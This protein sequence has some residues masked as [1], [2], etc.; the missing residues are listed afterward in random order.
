MS[1]PSS[2]AIGSDGTLWVG[3]FGNHRVLRFDDAAEKF[4]GPNAD[5]VLGQPD[6]VS[7]AV[8]TGAGDFDQP[9]ALAISPSGTLFVADSANHRVLRFDAAAL[10]LDGADADSVLGQTNLNGSVAPGLSR[11]ALGQPSALTLDAI[12][13]LFVSDPDNSRV[14][15]F[16]A[17][18]TTFKGAPASLVLG[19]PDFDTAAFTIT[20]T[21]VPFA[22]GLAF[23]PAGRLFIAQPGANRI[24]RFSPAIPPAPPVADTT[25]PTIRVK[26]RRSVDS[27]RNRVVFRG[28]ASDAD[29]VAGIEFRVSGQAGFQQAKGTTRWKAVVRPDKKKRKTVVRVRAI[30]ASGNKSRF[31][32]LKIFRR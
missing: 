29:A 5:G 14:L 30:D 7:R 2:V 10:A 3:E 8:G 26:G 12:G 31:L 17:A 25:R 19:Q 20:A 22:R 32:K 13:N 27:L 21:A 16:A 11:T 1:G 15:M 18:A 4:S 6:F 9:T 24:T 23:D 28:T